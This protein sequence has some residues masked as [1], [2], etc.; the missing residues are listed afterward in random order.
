MKLIKLTELNIPFFLSVFIISGSMNDIIEQ[1]CKIRLQTQSC[2]CQ[3]RSVQLS[4]I[5]SG[6]TVRFLLHN[7]LNYVEFLSKRVMCHPTTHPDFP[8]RDCFSM[9]L[10]EFWLFVG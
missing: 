5:T 7:F 9:F 10:G 3:E 6:Y 8:Y 1:I 2:A 4:I